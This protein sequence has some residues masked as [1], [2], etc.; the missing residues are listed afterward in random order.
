MEVEEDQPT[1]DDEKDK[2]SSL[3]REL[4]RIDKTE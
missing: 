2:Y 3:V 1:T 4:T